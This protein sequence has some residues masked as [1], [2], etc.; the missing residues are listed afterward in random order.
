M[1]YDE[2]DALPEIKNEEGDIIQEAREAGSLYSVRYQE[3]EAFESAYVR[4]KLKQLEG[5]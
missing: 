5:L 4:K 1:C 2:W 3:A